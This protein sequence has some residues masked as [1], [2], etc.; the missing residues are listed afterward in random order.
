MQLVQK[1]ICLLGDFAVG[2]TSLVRRYVEG[3]FND[4]YL[5]TIGIKISRKLLT[6][7][8]YQLN[9]MIWDLAG[10]EEFSGHDKNYLRGAA[11]ALLVCDLTRLETFP[12]LTMYAQQL[13]EI[14][15][16]AVMVVAANKAD[17]LQDNSVNMSELEAISQHIGCQFLLTSAKTGE[18]VEKIID[19]LADKLIRRAPLTDPNPSFG[20]LMLRVLD[21]LSL[22]RSFTLAVLSPALVVVEATEKFKEFQGDPKIGP[23]GRH[24]SELIWELVGCEEGLQE[25]LDGKLEIFSLENINRDVENGPGIFLSLKVLPLV[26]EKPEDGLLLILEDTTFTSTLEQELVQD[27]NELRLTKNSLSKANEELL[28]LNRLK[29]LFLSIAAHDLRSPLTAMRG[30]TDLAIKA[31]PQDAKTKAKQRS[32]FRLSNH[33]W[34]PKAD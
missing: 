10:G 24:I 29:S 25:I 32:I 12:I 13:I 33:L 14:S 7:Q 5:S 4:N 22:E 16:K 27:R 20:A 19:L 30:Y 23:I 17:L 11:G 21:H 9:M 18:N 3:S 28:K 31:L 2:K 8:S 1:K 15:P 6:R 34:T 26:K